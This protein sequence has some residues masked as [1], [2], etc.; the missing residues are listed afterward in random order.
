[1]W[2]RWDTSPQ[3]SFETRYDHIGAPCPADSHRRAR[4]GGGLRLRDAEDAGAE[5]GLVVEDQGSSLVARPNLEFRERGRE[6][7]L[8]GALRDEQPP[9][10]LAVREA[11]HDHRQDLLLACRENRPDQVHLEL[12]G[13]G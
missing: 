8:D 12:A 4:P 11:E 10:N 5:A 6:V 2:W 1:M 13:E 9:R 7:T 3:F